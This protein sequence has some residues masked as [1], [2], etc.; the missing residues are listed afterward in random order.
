MKDVGENAR[1]AAVRGGCLDAKGSP[2]PGADLA[3]MG[4]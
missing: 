2:A 3:N 4:A 1:S